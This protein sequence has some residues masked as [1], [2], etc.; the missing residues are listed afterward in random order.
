MENFLIGIDNWDE[1]ANY[2]FVV[3]RLYCFRF[4]QLIILL[5]TVDLADSIKF[6]SK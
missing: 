2:Y 5:V 3:F 6:R 4:L 1:I